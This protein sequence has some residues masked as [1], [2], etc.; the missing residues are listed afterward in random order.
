MNRTQ[1]EKGRNKSL[2]KLPNSKN[3]SGD[4]RMFLSI[5]CHQLSKLMHEVNENL[6]Y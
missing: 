2:N 4:K 3:G 1:L 6:E 5:T